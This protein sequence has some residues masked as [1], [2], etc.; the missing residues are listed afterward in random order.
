M[1]TTKLI[2]FFFCIAITSCNSDE[3]SKTGE[4]FA[5]ANQLQLYYSSDTKTDLLD[6]T[7]NTILPVTY[8]ESYIPSTLPPISNTLRYVYVGGVIEYNSEIKKYYWNTV[9]TGKQGYQNNKIFVR[10]SEK[11]TDTIDVKFKF[12]R[13]AM[14][15]GNGIYAYIEK[16]YYNGTLILEENS[17]PGAS[18]EYNK[19]VYIQK[20]EKKTMISFPK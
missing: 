3:I 19:R 11:D 9:I 7:N 1:K 17:K 6:L 18:I 16:L 13:E 8:E 10:I 20:K 12:K 14:N 15:G 2:I 5:R 4:P